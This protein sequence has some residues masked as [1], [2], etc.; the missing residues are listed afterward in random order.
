MLQ[1]NLPQI[2]TESYD[3]AEQDCA[4]PDKAFVLYNETQAELDD[5]CACPDRAFGVAHNGGQ[6]TAVFT[7][8]PLPNPTAE[9]TSTVTAV[10]T[11]LPGHANITYIY[12]MPII[13]K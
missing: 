4:C 1:T 13:S 11:T 6:Q 7:Q 3:D 12:F 10:A 2:I 9:P 8:T 5:D